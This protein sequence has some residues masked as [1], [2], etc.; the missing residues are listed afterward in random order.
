MKQI[1]IMMF[2]AAI[3]H[4][5]SRFAYANDVSGVE[6]SEQASAVLQESDV[7]G[8]KI[9]ITEPSRGQG[10][11]TSQGVRQHV[12]IQGIKAFILY[13]EYNNAD[14]AHK[15]AEAYSKNM[16]SVF[17]TGLWDGAQNNA[18]GDESWHGNDITSALLFRSGRTCVL[19]GCHGEDVAK[20][21]RVAELLAK[22]IERKIRKGGRIITSVIPWNKSLV[23]PPDVQERLRYVTVS[24]PEQSAE[25]RRHAALIW[26]AYGPSSP[27]SFPEKHPYEFAATEQEALQNLVSRKIATVLQP[28]L[29]PPAACELTTFYRQKTDDAPQPRSL[30]SHTSYKINGYRVAIK[31][32]IT[33]MNVDSL[34]IFIGR[35]KE[36][37]V[38]KEVFIVTPA[39]LTQETIKVR[40]GATTE[41]RLQAKTIELKG[42]AAEFR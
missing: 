22:E 30:L 37:P 39:T 23:A 41:E 3:S 33:N 38:A 25:S 12:A 29:F 21:K 18:M 16:A 11:W 24:T 26:P 14:E 6:S 13:G 10:W 32:G 27:V 5:S 15:M 4:L 8:I 36:Y 19:V 1:I 2:L 34:R 31:G 35:E 17:Y 9:E 7:D 42:L 28:E 40:E 20:R